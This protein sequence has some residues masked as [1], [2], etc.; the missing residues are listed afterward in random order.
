MIDSMQKILNRLLPVLLFAVV[1]SALTFVAG[2]SNAGSRT[3]DDKA[4]NNTATDI[5]VVVSIRPLHS[6]VA[7]VMEGI[8]EPTLLVDSASSPHDYSLKPSQARQIQHADVVFWIGHE[9]EAFLEKPLQSL[10]A[11]AHLV[12]LIDTPGLHTLN[13]RT[14]SSFSNHSNEHADDQH[15]SGIDPHIW[16][17]TDNAAVLAQQILSVLSS[18]DPE[19]AVTYQRN[20]RKL[21]ARIEQLHKELETLLEPVTEKPYIV[22]H[23]AFQYFETSFGLSAVAAITI[24]PEIQP[25]AGRVQS[26]QQNIR[27]SGAVCVFSEP[28]AKPSIVSIFVQGRQVKSGILDPLGAQV[29]AGEELYFSL[30]RN[31]AIS[32]RECLS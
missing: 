31:L 19:H 26:V 30:M 22:F 12:E 24:S 9:L 2:N 3:T 1:L 5:Q 16:L 13:F 21:L 15:H 23:D 29:P 7:A 17:D 8:A 25:G 32:M 27:D 28:Q 4:T 14:N 11:N 6:L 18:L 20:T 10:A